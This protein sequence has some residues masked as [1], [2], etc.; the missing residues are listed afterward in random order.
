MAPRSVIGGA[1]YA[2]AQEI[3]DAYVA[4]SGALS[5]HPYDAP[6]TI[7]GPGTVALEWEEDLRAPRLAAG[8]IRC[9]SPSAAAA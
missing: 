8:S 9:W 7:A 4:E 3:C 1:S 6:E 5:I 2:D